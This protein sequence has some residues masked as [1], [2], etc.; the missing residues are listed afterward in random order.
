MRIKSL[1]FF[2]ILSF[3]SLAA[4]AEYMGL[5]P[6]KLSEF[7]VY[8]K[9]D[10]V[11]ITW[12]TKSRKD[13][14]DFAIERSRD[15]KNFEILKKIGDDGVNP[16]SM[17]FFEVDNDPMPGW[18]YYRIKQDFSNGDYAYSDIA[19]IFFGMDRLRK[20][21]VIVAK[22]PNDPGTSK[23]NLSKFNQEKV[24]MVAR[25]TQGVEYYIHEMLFVK[26]NKLSVK[27]TPLVPPGFYT[28]TAS[29]IDELLGLELIAE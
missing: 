22:N 19:P 4:G 26:G 29:S 24:L 3:I 28:I 15:G 8:S 2:C 9:G 16:T 27:S 25:D 6:S 21:E 5:K 18:S 23:V 13:I 12:K 1:I 14:I 10:H 17:E 20:G 7:T 11:K